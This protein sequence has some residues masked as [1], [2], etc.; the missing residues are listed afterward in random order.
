MIIRSAAALA[1]LGLLAPLAACSGDSSDDPSGSR[2]PVVR[3]AEP[4]RLP[5]VLS[6]T[7]QLGTFGVPQELATRVAVNHINA[8]GGVLGRPLVVEAVDDATNPQQTTDQIN[9]LLQRRPAI[10]PLILGPTGS[11][12]AI[13]AAEL[14]FNAKVLLISPS[15]STPTLSDAQPKAERYFFRTTGSHA[16]QARAL[17]LLARQG[18]P[19]AGGGGPNRVCTTAA[20]VY[21]DDPYGEPIA[22]VFAQA[23]AARGGTV[24]LRVGVPTMPKASYADEVGRVVGAGVDCQVLVMFPGVGAQYAKDFKARVAEDATRDWA[25][26]V[27]LGSNGL[28]DE[29]FIKGGRANPADPAGPTAGEG[30]VLTFFDLNP[31]SAAYNEFKNMYRAHYPAAAPTDE[32]APY[33]ASQFD[34]V[35][36]AALAIQ[37]AGTASDVGAIRQA[38]F[39]VSRGGAAY[40]PSQIAEA[41]VAIGQGVD[42]DYNGA[43]GPVDFDEAGDVLNDF[44]VYAIRDAAFAELEPIKASAL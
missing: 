7:G 6:L 32:P 20:V 19:A 16:L 26:F 9:A 18:V 44:R 37:K 1:A 34:A 17:A 29:A 31:N 38:L 33:T 39:D 35:V 15:A 30:M 36:L 27:T 11:P 28:K 43:S 40:S 2:S 22:E 14:T 24:S 41:L 8:H 25:A 3:S 12:N 5:A 13:S 23:F 4:I 21:A 10:V 42:V